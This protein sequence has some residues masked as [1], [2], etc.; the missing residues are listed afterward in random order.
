M[1][2]EI[3]GYSDLDDETTCPHCGDVKDPEDDICEECA[4]DFAAD[5]DDDFEDEDE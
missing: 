5:S 3:L 1:T 4:E 2:L